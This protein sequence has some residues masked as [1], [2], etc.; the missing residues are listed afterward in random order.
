MRISPF[1]FGIEVEQAAAADAILYQGG[2]WSYANES[3]LFEQYGRTGWDLAYEYEN[4][5]NIS[6]DT[7]TPLFVVLH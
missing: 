4:E 1:Q 5:P 2:T 3:A 6:D 7:V